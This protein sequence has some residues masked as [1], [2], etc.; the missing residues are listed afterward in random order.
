M[1]VWELK[2]SANGSNLSKTLKLRVWGCTSR[3]IS[4]EAF[5]Q[6]AMVRPWKGPNAPH[7]AFRISSTNRCQGAANF[8]LPSSLALAWLA[9]PLRAG[10]LAFKSEAQVQQVRKFDLT[11]PQETLPN[12]FLEYCKHLPFAKAAIRY[13]P[14]I[15]PTLA[16]AHTWTLDS[17]ANL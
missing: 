17:Y 1:K 4:M 14:N 8:A 3:P 2:L 12:A 11:L 16:E 7:D 9:Q 13:T 5:R 10:N 15:L 6:L